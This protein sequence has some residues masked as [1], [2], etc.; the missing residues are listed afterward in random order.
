MSS[1]LEEENLLRILKDAATQTYGEERAK[2]LETSL[3]A[4]VR[5]L[6][7]TKKHPLDIDEEPAFA[8]I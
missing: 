1:P 5:S 8:R 3:Q 6:L 7:A 2:L 4:L